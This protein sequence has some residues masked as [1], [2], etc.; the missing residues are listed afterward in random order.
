MDPAELADRLSA[1]PRCRVCGH[2]VPVAVD[3]RARLLGL[4]GLRREQAGTGLL[5]P[6]CASVHTFGMRFAL[7]L[8]FLDGEGRP[9]AIWRR[10]PPRRLIWHRSAVAVL[11]I[12]SAQGGEFFVP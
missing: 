12:P 2:T 4:G 11:E 3:F 5:I 1:L 10:V 9:L 6:R 8:F 7:D